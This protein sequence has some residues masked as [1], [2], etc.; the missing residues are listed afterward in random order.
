VNSNGT[1]SENH[2][3]I[4]IS[5]HKINERIASK[6]KVKEGSNAASDLFWEHL[7]PH[8]LKLYNFVHKSLNFSE[9]ADDV[10]QETILR[11][12]KYFRSY[13]KDL[14][15]AAWLFSI[16][17]NG[18]KKHFKKAGKRPILNEVEGV[19]TTLTKQQDLVKDIYLYAEK[20][21]P[22]CREVFF[23]FY[24]NGFTISEISRIIHMKEGSIKAFLNQARNTLRELL[25]E[26]NA[27]Q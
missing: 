5:G 20:L 19:G 10:F 8:K 25:G 6:L 13:K 18:I 16:G 12:L 17:H 15:F 21:E 27:K 9:E 14:N 7:S 11:A 4:L 23:L 3:P 26:D 22:R 2:C 1:Y 24:Y